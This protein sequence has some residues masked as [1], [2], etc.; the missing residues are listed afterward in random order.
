MET[1]LLA[2]ALIVKNEE[3]N[4]P[5]CLEALASLGPLISEVC[6]YD[7][8]STD[9]TVEI[10][11][12]AG[13][14]VEVGHW[15]SDF[16]RARNASIAMTNAKW[17]L[18]VDADELV[19]ASV[20]ILQR[21]LRA[22]L[23]AGAVGYDTINLPVVD[24]RN[25]HELQT[26]PSVR[27]LRPTR[28][29]YEGAVHEQLVAIQDGATLTSFEVGRNVVALMHR[30][31]GDDEL[32]AAKLVRNAAI[33]D[34]VVAEAEAGHDDAA[35]IR[36]LVDRARSVRAADPDAALADFRRV[37]SIKSTIPYRLWGLEQLA[38]CLIDAKELSEAAD[39]IAQLRR[40]GGSASF[41][42]YLDARRLAEAHDAAGALRLLQGIDVL[43]TS[44][45]VVQS[46]MVLLKAR[47]GVCLHVG[48]YD[49]AAACLIRLMASYG[50]VA[51]KQGDLLLTLW[52]A[53]PV[54]VLSDVL[55][56]ADRGHLATVIEELAASRHPGP[57]VA[58]ALRRKSARAE[59]PVPVA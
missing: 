5:S 37:R 48:Q 6:V 41:C 28:A 44:M 30:G 33:V 1:P 51:R 20:P 54:E 46:P 21:T 31:Y 29:R 42:D 34:V 59:R 35:L 15:D 40:E 56:E 17:V 26:L 38:D 16:A 2:A 43:E 52:G 58:D 13:G 3:V 7:T 27:L 23:Q 53:L 24:V 57:I 49:E 18:I 10:A 12:E 50:Q 25:G 45:R 55:V 36:A 39:V 14:R 22:A 4:L 9:R 32:Y 47:M 19:V 8:G 11:R